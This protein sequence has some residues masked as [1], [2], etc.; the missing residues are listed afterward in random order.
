MLRGCDL[1]GFIPTTDFPR[2]VTFYQDILGLPLLEQTPFAL[3]FGVNTGTLRVTLV[4]ELHA[5]PYTVIGWVVEDIV[6][7]VFELTSKGVSFVWYAGIDQDESG[8]WRT[9][10]GELVAW[11]H[12]PDG[13]TL[14]LTEFAKPGS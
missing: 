12:D 14:S 7:T 11:F 8:I 3:V 10:A 6:D 2:A 1:I 4:P 5:A 13:N 9:P